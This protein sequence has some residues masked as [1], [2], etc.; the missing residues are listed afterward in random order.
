MSRDKDVRD[1][2]ILKAISG[3][4]SPSSLGIQI[5]DDYLMREKMENRREAGFWVS[6]K[7][8]SEPRSEVE[9]SFWKSEKMLEAL[10]LE[11]WKKDQDEKESHLAEEYDEDRMPILVSKR[12][13]KI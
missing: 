3:S 8:L 2:V 13:I 7:W 12:V 1:L 4:D 10:H 11:R 9:K 5:E 6:K